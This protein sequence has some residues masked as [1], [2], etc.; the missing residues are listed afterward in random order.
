M[1]DEVDDLL[2]GNLD[3]AP[4]IDS[5]T[6]P[7]T[8]QRAP[9]PSVAPGT[10]KEEPLQAPGTTS[11]SAFP[12]MPPSISQNGEGNHVPRPLD[13]SI[14]SIVG[15]DYDAPP[16]NDARKGLRDPNISRAGYV[17]LLNGVLSSGCLWASTRGFLDLPCLFKDGYWPLLSLSKYLV[18][19]IFTMSVWLRFSCTIC[20]ISCI[21]H[22][23]GLSKTCQWFIIS[24]K[25]SIRLSNA[26]H[27]ESSLACLSQTL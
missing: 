9:S 20:N 17:L 13:S 6:S 4:L 25:S 12:S 11:V 19:R 7:R 2:Y 14:V 26:L 18:S 15:G 8:E 21:K 23:F 24:L 16:G 22:S 3:K 5:L 1:A 27:R 10:V